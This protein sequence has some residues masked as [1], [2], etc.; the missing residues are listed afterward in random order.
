[1]AWPEQIGLLLAR[2]DS[3][4]SQALRWGLCGLR[5]SLQAVLDEVP[6]DPGCV[7]LRE[8]LAE[9]APLLG[10][11]GPTPPSLP[12]DG[13][14]ASAAPETAAGPFPATPRLLPLVRAA[15][16][17]ARLGAMLRGAPLREGSDEEIWNDLH[18]LLL[19]AAPDLAEEWRQR[20]LSA[21]AQ[22]GAR[23]DPDRAEALPLGSIPV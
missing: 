19:R 18:L 21:A 1:M 17:D 12:P 13:T 9:L 4:A 2:S 8:L 7:E 10:P 22:V 20:C 16:A 6:D 14:G 23:A 3:R 5:A 11:A 15:A